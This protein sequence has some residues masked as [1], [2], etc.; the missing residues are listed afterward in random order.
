MRRREA[1]AKAPIIAPA[2]RRSLGNITASLA[3]LDELPEF[4]PVIGM[5][6]VS[7]DIDPLLAELTEAFAG[8]F[9]ANARDVLTTIVF[10]H[11]VTRLAA[12]GNILPQVSQSTAREA[13]RY[14]WQTGCGLHACFGTTAAITE[15]VEPQGQ[16]EDSVID[17]AVAN[18]DE[19]V[20]KFTE[21]C[22][23]R[24]KRRNTREPLFDIGRLQ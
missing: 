21:A 1:I 4:A 19:H 24:Q 17:R 3:M 18:G 6:D 22:L 13:L 16:D 2:H 8:V 7:G 10:V 14:A 12:L 15:E 5:I 20:I 23:R 11:S 9:L